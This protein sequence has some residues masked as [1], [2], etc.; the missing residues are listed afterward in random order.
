MTSRTVHYPFTLIPLGYWLADWSHGVDQAVPLVRVIPPTSF[1]ERAVSTR[2][3]DFARQ[4]SARRLYF[5]LPASRVEE[6]SYRKRPSVENEI[7]SNTV[8]RVSEFHF[9]GNLLWALFYR[10]QRMTIFPKP[11]RLIS[12]DEDR[13]GN[14]S[15]GTL[16]QQVC[17]PRPNIFLS[18]DI[19]KIYYFSIKKWYVI[20]IFYWKIYSFLRENIDFKSI[21]TIA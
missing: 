3:C 16:R 12:T 2:R 15:L 8:W 9:L 6:S 4:I 19:T 14:F 20:K 17:P 13:D 5:I 1:Q 21:T 11:F 10:V 18:K 7:L